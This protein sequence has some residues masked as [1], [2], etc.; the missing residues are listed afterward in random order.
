MT[1]YVI[2]DLHL[3]H[4]NII[5]FCRPQ[6][7]SLAQMESVIVQKWNGVVTFQDTVYVVG[8]VLFN[9]KSFE[10]L[11]YLK[12]TKILI[13][14]NHDA[15][16]T[17]QKYLNHFKKILGVGTYYHQNEAICLTHIPIHPSCFSRYAYNIHGHLHNKTIDDLRYI[18]VSCE[19]L[20]FVPADLNRLIAER[21]KICT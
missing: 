16:Y 4:K 15:A 2:S 9:K 5:G 3:G 14:G 12:G 6:F 10:L 13:A 17:T 20:N 1:D 19:Q 11:E 21:K 7:T 8:D 18:N